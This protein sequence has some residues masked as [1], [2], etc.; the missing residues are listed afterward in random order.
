MITTYR[1]VAIIAAGLAVFSM[2]TGSISAQVVVEG[3]VEAEVV[4]AGICYDEAEPTTC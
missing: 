1:F 4:T 2:G 3:G